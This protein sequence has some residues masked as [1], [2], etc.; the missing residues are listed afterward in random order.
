MPLQ[1]HHAPPG[2]TI[3]AKDH[4]GGSRTKA[5]RNPAGSPYFAGVRRGTSD[6]RLRPSQVPVTQPGDA[7][8]GDADRMADLIAP[9]NGEAPSVAPSPVSYAPSA[10]WDVVDSPGRPLAG[11][12]RPSAFAI[13]LADVRVHTGT[14][15]SASAG[16]L[17]ARAYTVG[18]DIVLGD[19]YDADSPR[20]R[21]LLA[22]ELAHVAQQ[23]AHGRPPL[24]YRQGSDDD[25]PPT[26]GNLPRR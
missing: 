6:R 10:V 25:P 16:A 19:G 17:N 2:A 24:V 12:E 18:D 7:V 22:H 4:D 26:Y 9:R 1:R 13:D 21:R 20:G 11:H 3:P 15:A 23:R 5:V 14:A 8:E